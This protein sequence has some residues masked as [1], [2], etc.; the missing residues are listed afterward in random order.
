MDKKSR[1]MIIVCILVALLSF[2]GGVLYR[3]DAYAPIIEKQQAEYDSLQIQ[4]Y[5]FFKVPMD[6]S[7]A[8]RWLDWAAEQYQYRI[9]HNMFD[10]ASL[11]VYQGGIALFDSIRALF[12]EYE[13]EYY[14]K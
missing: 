14:P 7:L 1:I 4:L 12:F 8:Y 6:I 9:D 5:Q 3:Y 13:E 11:E 10:Q 2:L